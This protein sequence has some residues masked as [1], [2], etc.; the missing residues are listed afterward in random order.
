MGGT[1][2]ILQ[3]RTIPL[4]PFKHANQA[5]PLTVAPHRHSYSNS[6]N[7]IGARNARHKRGYPIRPITLLVLALLLSTLFTVAISFSFLGYEADE[8]YFMQT[9]NNVAETNPGIVLLG[10]NVDVDV[11]EPSIGIR[12]SILGC[13]NG[14]LLEGSA[15]L[16][17]S[18]LCAIPFDNYVLTSTLRA[19]S[20]SNTTIPIQKLATI[21]QASIWRPMKLLSSSSSS[22]IPT[23]DIDLYVSRPIQARMITLLLFALS[24]F[25]TH[26][27]LISVYL[28]RKRS[29]SQVPRSAKP[30]LK[31]LGGSLML[32]NAMPDAPGYD[33]VLIDCIGF[34]PQMILSGLS[35][36][37]LLLLMILRELEGMQD[38]DG[39]V[40]VALALTST[41]SLLHSGR[42][43]QS[44]KLAPPPSPAAFHTDP[45][46]DLKPWTKTESGPNPSSPLKR[47][48]LGAKR[49][50]QTRTPSISLERGHLLRDEGDTT[51]GVFDTQA[52]SHSSSVLARASSSLSTAISSSFHTTASTSPS[53]VIASR[54]PSPSHLRSRSSVFS[55]FG[56]RPGSYYRSLERT[57]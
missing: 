46:P 54:S 25:L 42:V 34:F 43:T 28:A 9:L 20:A 23:R 38:E 8:P 17:G 29:T 14:Y 37:I 44:A 56:G 26:A 52:S 50:Y 36:L 31:H 47:L 22:Q 18:D 13:G 48:I 57:A 53:F 6:G 4:L 40:N 41:S 5:M 15:G 49:R 30:I 33:G 21:D 3:S 11:D 51:E 1:T 32:R 12:W 10:E 55:G 2:P 7:P 35:V 16:H 45:T 39:R 24:W 19:V 27:T